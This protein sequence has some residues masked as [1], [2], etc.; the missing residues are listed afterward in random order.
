MPWSSI[1]ESSGDSAVAV[2]RQGFGHARRGAT[3]GAGLDVQTTSELPAVAVHRP[4]F[5]VKSVEIPRCSSWTRLCS[6]AQPVETPQ[7]Q[8]F[9]FWGPV[10]RYRAGGPCHEDR[11]R[12]AQTPGSSLLR[13]WHPLISLHACRYST[14]RTTTTTTRLRQ[15]ARTLFFCVAQ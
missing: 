13:V 11:G 14:V 7:V 15:V 4:I 12:V 6:F 1:A 8:F 10:Q 9:S 3:T 5:S 2:L